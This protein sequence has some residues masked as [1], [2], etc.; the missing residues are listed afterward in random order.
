MARNV[1]DARTK[2]E[3]K[4]AIAGAVALYMASR[5]P[6]SEVVIVASDKDQSRGRVL[7]AI[8]YG[9]EKGPL[10]A[11]AKI[12]KDAIELDNKSMIQA[13]PADWQ[14]AVG[15][16][17]SAVIFDE[18]HSW[19]YENQRRLF[20]EL[21]IPPT[22]PEG[23]RWIA[24]YAGWEGESELLWEW[25]NLAL[26]GEKIHDDYPIYKNQAASLLAF[27]DTGPDSWRMPWM[28][29]EYIEQTR[30][31]ERA[32][33]FRRIWLNEWVSNESQFLPEGAWD[34]CVSPD[35]KPFGLGENQRLV[36]GADASTSRDFTS[37]I[38]AEY[39]RELNTTD[40]R[41][42]RFWKPKKGLLRFGKPTIDCL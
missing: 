33:T 31:S 41:L 14:G 35:L 7:R 16:N 4:S 10:S 32:N 19:I 39:S 30:T 5:K 3:G 34:A 8:K 21:V 15:G 36:L 1:L 38:G 42:V 18:L 29:S 2:K 25:W 17:Y 9:I 13:I 37:L 23:V 12:Y 24:S 22:Q 26:A 20:D 6:Y 27:V 28:T 40:I 11:H